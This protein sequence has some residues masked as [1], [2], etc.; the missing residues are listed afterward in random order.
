MKRACLLLLLATALVSLA[1]IGCSSDENQP[2]FTRVRVN[3]ACGVVPLSVEGYATVTGGNE[4]GSPTGGNNNLEIRWAFG[5]GGTSQTSISYHVYADTGTFDVVVTAQD[6]DG[7][8][9]T[10]TVPV[11]VYADTLNVAASSSAE[12]GATTADTVRFNLIAEAC[13]IDPYNDDDYRNLQFIWNMDDADTTIYTGRAP[14]FQYTAP[15]DYAVTVA[16]TYAALA[17][18]RRDTLNLTISGP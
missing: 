3:P 7:K 10:Y 9:A 14:E 4:T 15:G 12:L 17:V 16:V 1:V 8:S 18:T 11:V 5:D 13:G 2:V 6:E